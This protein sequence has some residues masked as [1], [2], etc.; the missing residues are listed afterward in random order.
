MCGATIAKHARNGDK[1]HIF[2]VAEGM[3]ARD[4][5]GKVARGKELLQSAARKAAAILGAESV[6]F[7]DH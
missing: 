1:V 6:D 4:E 3:T 7:G 5:A 2:I